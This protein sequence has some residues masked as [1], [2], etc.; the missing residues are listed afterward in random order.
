MEE[1]RETRVGR[2]CPECEVPD[3]EPTWHDAV[4]AAAQRVRAACAATER[5]GTKNRTDLPSTEPASVDELRE[6]VL[7]PLYRAAAAVPS[8][9][10]RE[11]TKVAKT[12]Q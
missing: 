2:S 11:V 5:E 8:V 4:L 9:E 10:L 6:C 1:K 7:A 3:L 12:K